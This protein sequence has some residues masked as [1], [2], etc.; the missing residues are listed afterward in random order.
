ML[1]LDETFGVKMYLYGMFLG[2][3]LSFCEKLVKIHHSLYY[4]FASTLQ[5]WY[6]KNGRGTVL[7]QVEEGF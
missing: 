2:K 6:D 3:G 7:K 1:F 5:I 4:K